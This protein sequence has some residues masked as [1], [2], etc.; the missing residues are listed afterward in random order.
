MRRS[1]SATLAVAAAIWAAQAAGVSAQT[2]DWS[3]AYLGAF[4]G[5]V[6]GDSAATTEI[7]CVDGGYICSPVQYLD[8]GALVGATGSGSAGAT[9][10]IGG[11][12]IGR[13]WQNGEVV[14]G[15]E[16][17][18]GAMPLS[19]T[20]GGSAASVNAGIVNNGV[21][22]TF[23]MHVTASTDWLAT[24]RA[25]VGFLPLPG[26]LLYGTAGIAATTLTVS[27]A[28]AD[29]YVFT[30]YSGPSGGHE[31][32]STSEFRT[33]LVLGAGAEWAMAE[34][35]T[36]RAEYLH[37]DFGTL[38]VAGSISYADLWIDVNP[39]NS[40]ASLSTDIV[41]VGLAYGF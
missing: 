9:A 25:R 20:N 16:A 11:G 2:P 39:A 27:N 10:F 8:N 17:D 22:A 31:N 30:D 29:D 3:G 26:L 37:A 21:P 23:S 5:S 38:A 28:Y 35:W 1:I 15:L 33:A 32:A 6:S 34:H 19:I 41:R 14:Y 18:I 7:G 4:A 24:A 12:F 13:N 36:M 40:T